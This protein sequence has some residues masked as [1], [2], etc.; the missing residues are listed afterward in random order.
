MGG[1]GYGL[2]PGGAPGGGPAGG[3]SLSAGPCTANSANPSRGR[4]IPAAPDGPGRP[5]GMLSPMPGGRI[6]PGGRVPPGGPIRPG[7]FGPRNIGFEPGT[8][9]GPYGP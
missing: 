4:L 2:P 3:M 6:P 5:S 7:K 8:L 1:P 9:P